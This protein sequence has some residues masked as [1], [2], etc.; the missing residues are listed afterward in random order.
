M[1]CVAGFLV[2]PA[3]STPVT[4]LFWGPAKG[5]T[6]SPVDMTDNGSL[7]RLYCIEH[8]KYVEYVGSKIF[9]LELI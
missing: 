2:H 3:A 5:V 4:M 9:V 8:N 6:V 7:G 1:Y